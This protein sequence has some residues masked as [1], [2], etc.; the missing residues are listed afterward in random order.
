MPAASIYLQD[1][2]LNHLFRTAT[3]S[4]PANLYVGLYTAMPTSSGG[5][6]EVSGG[7]YARIGLGPADASWAAPTQVSSAAQTKNSS[8]INFGTATANWGT[9]LGFG[10]FDALTVG[11]MLIFGTLTANKTVNTN[12]AFQFPV[13]QLTV[14]LS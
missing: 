14:S 2:L 10:I 1:G 3:F 13:N 6:T 5:G 7:S 9:I 4:K 12:D 8:I 11:N